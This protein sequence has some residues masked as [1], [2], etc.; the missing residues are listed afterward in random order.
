MPCDATMLRCRLNM[1]TCLSEYFA[2]IVR[3]CYVASDIIIPLLASSSRLV[4]LCLS[5]DLHTIASLLIVGIPFFFIRRAYNHFRK[6]CSVSSDES[7]LQ[8]FIKLNLP[9]A[10]SSSCHASPSQPYPYVTSH[11]FIRISRRY[12]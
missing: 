2:F 10:S 5:S 6:R 12:T 7:S 11:L 9:F 1:M 3:V 4:P 8:Y